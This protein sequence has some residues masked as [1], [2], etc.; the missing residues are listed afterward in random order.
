MYLCRNGSVCV[1]VLSLEGPGL[2]TDALLTCP[3]VPAPVELPRE[4]SLRV[5]LCV[6]ERE[7]KIR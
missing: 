4:K 7:T 2:D 1:E 5:L 6:C 3:L